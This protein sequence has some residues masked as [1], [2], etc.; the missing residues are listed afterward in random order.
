MIDY[1]TCLQSVAAI[2]SAVAAI[3][4]VYVARSTFTFQRQSLLKKNTIDQI[5]KLLQQLQYFKSLTG[6]AVLG[7]ADD[8]FTN[9]N[10]RI[11]ETQECILVLESMISVS[12]KA[13][14]KK[15]SDIVRD[16]DEASIYALDENT[17]NNELK[18]QLDI[19]ICIL[20]NIYHKELK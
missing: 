15:V 2:S 3:A 14:L 9:I 18:S 12:A 20:Q 16:L 6:Q 7:T 10:L 13:E 11:S 19:S 4:A 1:N 8:D 17:P 5:Q